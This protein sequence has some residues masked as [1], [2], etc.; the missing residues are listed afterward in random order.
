MNPEKKKIFSFKI[1]G[2][3]KTDREEKKQ[4]EWYDDY[5]KDNQDEL[6]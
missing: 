1:F 3:S 2:D 6:V 5:T 4:L